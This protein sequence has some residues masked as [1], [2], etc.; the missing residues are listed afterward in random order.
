MPVPVN[1][2]TSDMPG[3]LFAGREYVKGRLLQF[4]ELLPGVEF[5]DG[6]RRI[7]RRS[8]NEK[9]FLV[10]DD[11]SREAAPTWSVKRRETGRVMAEGFVYCR[12]KTVA[13]LNKE[14]A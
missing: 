13:S 6:V 10:S 1:E 4:C 7:W 14:S 11:L 3:P 5:G 12:D 9:W 2:S 8:R